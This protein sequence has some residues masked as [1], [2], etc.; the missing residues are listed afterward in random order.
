MPVPTH[1]P[2]HDA[3]TGGRDESPQHLSNTLLDGYAN[4]D[5]LSY[6]DMIGILDD[7]GACRKA[8]FMSLGE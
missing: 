3:S 8:Q 1:P 5:R 4:L 2:S 7:P 6:T